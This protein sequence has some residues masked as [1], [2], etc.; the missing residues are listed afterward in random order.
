ME[1]ISCDFWWPQIWITIK[2]YVTTCNICFCSKAHYHR[3]YRL[4]RPL[5]IPKKPWSSI[6]MD[7]IIDLPSSKA[8]DSIFVVVDQ[9]TKMAHFMPCNKMVRDEEI[10]RL[11]MDNI[12][13][14]HG[15]L[16]TS[17]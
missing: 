14:Y 10:A 8:Y 2:D 12:Y 5:P 4:L 1:L 11:F 7:F 9:V 17:F 15:L 13:K 3:P 16:T 6:S